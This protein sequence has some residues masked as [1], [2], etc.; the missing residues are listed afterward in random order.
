MDVSSEWVTALREL[1]ASQAL[2][3]LST[4]DRSGPH[5]SL[6]AFAPF[7]DL[8]GI[9][10]A[11]PRTTRKFAHLSSNPRGALLVD[12]RSNTPAD[13]TRAVAAT[14]RGVVETVPPED[15]KAFLGLYLG[16]HPHLSDFVRAPS[17]ALLQLRVEAY[18]LVR[19]FQEVTEIRVQP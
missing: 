1:L 17:C 14:A 19:R 9:L 18:S 16:R 4:H 10:F 5:A 11:T 2:G 12:N 15:E 6:V 8:R 13:F 7:E 3:V